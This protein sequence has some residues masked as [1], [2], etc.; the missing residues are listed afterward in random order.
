M[1]WIRL[2][3]AQVSRLDTVAV[4][5]AKAPA[6]DE[7]ARV[8]DA[9]VVAEEAMLR[10]EAK[11]TRLEVEHT[12]LLLKIRVAEDEVSSLQSQADKDKESMEEDY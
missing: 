2:K 11:A 4:G 12:S 5:D 6:K 3:E 9:L 7:L 8:Q 1:R 10:V